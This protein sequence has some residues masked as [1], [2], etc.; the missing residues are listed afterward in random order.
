MY[1]K[2]RPGKAGKGSVQIKSSNDRLQL[3]FSFGGKRHYLSTGYP[4]TPQCRKLAQMRA[5]E[6][7]KDILYK[8][9]DP[10]LEK[11]KPKSALST[12][13]PITPIS[14]PRPTLADLWKKF[15]DW[16]RPQCAPS[17]MKNQYKAFSSYL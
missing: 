8:R 17:T 2:N 16:K 6:I 11:Y 7:E 15:V 14:T 4:N 5:S 12:V 1:S 9:L 10:T 13:T 3:V